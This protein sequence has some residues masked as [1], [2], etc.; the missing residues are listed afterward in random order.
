MLELGLIPLVNKIKANFKT[1]DYDWLIHFDTFCEKV[2]KIPRF[3]SPP[4]KE[5]MDQI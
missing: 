5:Y 4:Y 2:L 1:L 3:K